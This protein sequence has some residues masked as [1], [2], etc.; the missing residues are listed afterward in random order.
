MGWGGDVNVHVKLQKHLMQTSAMLFADGAKAWKKF[1]RAQKMKFSEVS[2][3]RMQFCSKKRGP[4][5]KA[6]GTQ[7]LDRKWQSM[8]RFVPKE[9]RNKDRLTR[10]VNECIRNYMCS[11]SFVERIGAVRTL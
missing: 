6:A 7:C 2:H 9:L 3:K 8:K 11:P 5:K 4:R 10:D 1:A